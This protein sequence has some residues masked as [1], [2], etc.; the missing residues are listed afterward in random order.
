M[1]IPTLFCIFIY[2]VTT[3][4][5]GWREADEHDTVTG[6]LQNVVSLN[7]NTYRTVQSTGKHHGSS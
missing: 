3:A 4:V 2:A 6:T 7:A 5:V 1:I